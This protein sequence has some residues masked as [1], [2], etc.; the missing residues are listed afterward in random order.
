MVILVNDDELTTV[1][2]NG[3]DEDGNAYTQTD[4]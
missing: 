2:D 1:V 4:R 3:D